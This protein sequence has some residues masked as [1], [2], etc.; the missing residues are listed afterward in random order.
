MTDFWNA[1]LYDDKH[2]FVSTYGE[3][4]IELVEVTKGEHVLDIGCGTGDLA[5]TLHERG[6]YVVGVDLSANMI[7]QASAKYPHVTFAVADATS[8]PY[9]E[10]FDCVFSNAALHWMKEPEAVATSMYN[11]LNNGGRIVVEFGGAGNVET[12]TTELIAQIR[13]AGI[14]YRDE[15]FPWYFPTIG[16]YTTILERV[17][18]RVAYA[19]HFDRPTPL[20]G[21]EGLRNWLDMFS[22]SLF[23]GIAPHVKERV[24]NETVAH[25]RDKLYK[26][27][28][29][30]A[31]YKRIRIVA[32]K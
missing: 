14:T 10:Q 3:S 6:A 24:F 19:C 4:V 1:T 7:E 31:D 9:A 12:I 22:G 16:Q 25:S 28:T 8:L 21:E 5:N 13:A 32:Y 20:D 26:D 15:Q 11:S 30:V 18:F 27:G 17:G 29:W 2:A 23:D